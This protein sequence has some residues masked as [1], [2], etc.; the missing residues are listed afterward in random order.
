[1]GAKVELLPCGAVAAPAGST[2]WVAWLVLLFQYQTSRPSRRTSDSPSCTGTAI[3]TC[4][5]SA[6]Q[7]WTVCEPDSQDSADS[8]SP[9][10]AFG[11]LGI[12]SA[13]DSWTT[14]VIGGSTRAE[15]TAARSW[16][17]VRDGSDGAAWAPDIAKPA[18]DHP[19]QGHRARWDSPPGDAR[20]PALGN[21]AASGVIGP[22]ER[23]G[24]PCRAGSD[25][26]I[27]CLSHNTARGGQ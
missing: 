25:V 5:G 15:F 7:I 27:G 22:G 6:Y 24:V 20:E 19:G 10:P 8:G 16:T 9:E 2:R 21:H 4:A 3:R 14:A 12:P 23:A 13:A 11:R 26:V 17:G 1:M 18:P